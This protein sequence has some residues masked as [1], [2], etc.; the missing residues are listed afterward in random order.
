MQ[1]AQRKLPL[2]AVQLYNDFIHGQISRRAFMEGVQGLCIGLAAATMRIM[3]L[4]SSFA[5]G[6]RS[7]YHTSC[8]RLLSFLISNTFCMPRFFMCLTIPQ[9]PCCLPAS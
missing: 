2:E 5:G 7:K 4:A 6:T 9:V 3:R 1:P 8:S